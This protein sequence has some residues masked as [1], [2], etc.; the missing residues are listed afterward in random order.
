MMENGKIIKKNGEGFIY[1]KDNSYL[2]VF[3][4]NDNIDENS[5]GIFN[6][7]NET[8]YRK[9]NLNT[10]EWIHFIE[11]ILLCYNGN[12]TKI[13]FLNQL[14]DNLLKN[15]IFLFIIYFINFMNIIIC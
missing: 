15:I 5:E 11:M 10:Y 9:I 14:S 2:K 12:K 1:F 4:K 8:Q 6:L 7:V 13:V 3:W